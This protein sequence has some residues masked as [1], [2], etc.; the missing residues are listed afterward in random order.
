VVDEQRPEMVGC[1]SCRIAVTVEAFVGQ[2][3]LTA[4]DGCQES[5][6]LGGALPGDD[7]FGTIR[8]AK[9]VD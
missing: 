2:G 3:S 6:D 5:L 1:P 7:A 8:L 9:Y 4:R